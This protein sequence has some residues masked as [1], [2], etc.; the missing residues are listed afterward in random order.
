LLIKLNYCAAVTGPGEA[1][2]E[3][4]KVIDAPGR[5]YLFAGG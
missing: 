3:L 2:L 4:T 1:L 5:P